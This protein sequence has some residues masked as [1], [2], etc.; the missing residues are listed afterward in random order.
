GLRIN[1]NDFQVH[2]V[3]GIALLEQG[4]SQAAE[5]HFRWCLARQPNHGGAN[6]GLLE[7]TKVR[8]GRAPISNS[9]N[10]SF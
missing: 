3:L 4:N 1:F 6:R 7:A 9:T 2:Y 10:S 5:Q 8:V